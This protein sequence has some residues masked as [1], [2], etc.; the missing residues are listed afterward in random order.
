MGAYM[1][2]IKIKREAQKIRYT[3]EYPLEDYGVLTLR[4]LR[5][6]VNEDEAFSIHDS[7]EGMQSTYTLSVSGTRMETPEELALRVAKEELYMVNYKAFHDKY[8]KK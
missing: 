7:D 2:P 3:K 6:Y 5:K 8:D 4:E 1:Y